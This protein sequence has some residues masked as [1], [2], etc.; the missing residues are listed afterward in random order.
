MTCPIQKPRLMLRLRDHFV[1]PPPYR[2]WCN[3]C[4]IGFNNIPE[5]QAHNR[6]KLAVH[7]GKS[8]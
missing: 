5:L 3:A 8:Q 2:A 7:Q 1:I 4:S 6:K